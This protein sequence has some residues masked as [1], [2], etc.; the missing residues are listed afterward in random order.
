MTEQELIS[1][2]VVEDWKHAGNKR[3]SFAI[4]QSS[5]MKAI[6]LTVIFLSS[7]LLYFYLEEDSYDYGETVEF[8]HVKNRILP[9]KKLNLTSGK[10]RYAKGVSL[11]SLW[12]N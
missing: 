6:V 8:D 9:L 5:T 10:V 12:Q 7:T 2:E 11:I 3:T 4:M 1:A